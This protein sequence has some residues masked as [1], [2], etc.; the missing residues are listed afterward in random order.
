MIA[1]PA[2]LLPEHAPAAA[3]LHAAATSTRP[4]AEPWTAEALA[5]RLGLDG[6]AGFGAWTAAGLAGWILAR[7]A[8][9]EAEVVDI[10]VAP[11]L[12]RRGLGRALLEHAAAH[13]AAAGARRL[14][15]E[16]A[17]GNV[18]AL[19]L[20][21]SRG[22]AAVGRRPAYYRARGRPPEDAIVMARALDRDD[23]ARST[24]R[25]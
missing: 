2:P 8:A 15:L 22:F 14:V 7:R 25:R 4:G 6:W 10:C 11:A 19:A 13:M 24:L 21:R 3:V 23:Q 9:D 17:A 5:R 18:P 20:Y 1:G 16:V 12:R